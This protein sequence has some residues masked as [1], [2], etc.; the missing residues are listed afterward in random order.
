MAVQTLT[1]G[2]ERLPQ[3]GVWLEEACA[4]GSRQDSPAVQGFNEI[5]INESAKSFRRTNPPIQM[6]EKIPELE[7]DVANSEQLINRYLGIFVNLIREAAQSDENARAFDVWADGQDLAE[8]FE[9]YEEKLVP[10]WKTHAEIFRKIVKGWN[11]RAAAGEI[12]PD[13]PPRLTIRVAHLDLHIRTLTEQVTKKH[14]NDLVARLLM[15]IGKQRELSLAE[16][17]RLVDAV[18]LNWKVKEEPSVRRA[19]WYGDDGR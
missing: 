16:Q 7:S 17:F 13:L 9:S 12:E 5:L 19:D 6:A 10:L 2:T 4:R 1:K 14:D 3:F 15:R 18:R 8:V 11:R